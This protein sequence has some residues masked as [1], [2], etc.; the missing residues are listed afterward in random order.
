MAELS[1]DI[2][3]N[4]VKILQDIQKEINWLDNDFPKAILSIDGVVENK[5]LNNYQLDID[6]IKQ[7][8]LMSRNRD[9][10]SNRTNFGIHKSDFI[11]VHK[12]K[13]V[14]AKLCSTGEQKAMLIAIILAQINYSIRQKHSM[15]ILLLDEIF[16]HLDDK[17]KQYLV[18]FFLTVG[19]QLWVT[20]TDL[21]GIECLAQKA[22]LIQLT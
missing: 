6:F 21:R 17:R 22:Q 3:T 16:V 8:L 13:N 7:E 2:A 20:A 12:A 1:I 11:V 9:K 4:R 15:P 19:L 14:L 5:I 18:D 10:A